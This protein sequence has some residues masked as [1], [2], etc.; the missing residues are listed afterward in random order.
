MRRRASLAALTLCVSLPL[1]SAAGQGRFYVGALV[2]AGRLDAELGGAGAP[3]DELTGAIF[4]FEG[5]A[6]I[7]KVELDLRYAT[8]TLEA[9][10]SQLALDLVEAELLVGVRPISWVTLRVG[11]H[12]RSFTPESGGTDRWLFWEV[13]G[14]V[15]PAVLAPQLRTYFEIWAALAGDVN[16]GSGFGG[17]RGLEAGLMYRFRGAPFWGRVGYR[18]DRGS[19]ENGARKDSVQE[20]LLVVGVGAR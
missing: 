16:F 19:L 8:G 12:A 2:G 5:R 6:T 9:D 10:Q 13:R 14:R 4:G 1:A 7:W 15:E 3:R 18:V 11:P 20:L 17:G